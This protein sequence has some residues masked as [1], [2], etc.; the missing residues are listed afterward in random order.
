MKKIEYQIVSRSADETRR[1]GALLGRHAVPGLVIALNGELGSGK[2]CLTQG[3]AQ[4]LAVPEDLYVTS[5]SFS[6]VNEY[7]GQL[8]LIH[9]D[10]FRIETIT[11]L[12]DVGLEEMMGSRE[13]T[14]IEWADKLPE[15]LPEER[16]SISI[17]ILDHETRRLAL[18]ASGQGPCNL[19]EKCLDEFVS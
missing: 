2:T 13:V 18:T 12:H 3:I 15:I 8:P 10:L 1:F 17:E 4:G 19:V 11:D 7:P 9:V 16:L 14:V 5:P 6:I